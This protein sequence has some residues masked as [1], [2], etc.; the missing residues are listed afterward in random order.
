MAGDVGGKIHGAIDLQLTTA[1]NLTISSSQVT[2]GGVGTVTSVTYTG[3][4]V[5]QSA[6]PTTAVTTSGTLT[7]TLKTQTANTHLAGPTTGAAATPTFRAMVTA[8]LPAALAGTSLNLGGTTLTQYV[9]NSWSPVANSFT[10]SG[11]GGTAVW[12]ASYTRIGRIVLLT[13]T[14]TNSNGGTT[15]SAT[16]VSNITGLPVANVGTWGAPCYDQG[17]GS[18]IANGILN[19]VGSLFTPTWTAKTAVCI[20]FYYLCGTD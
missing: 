6:T 11:V 4:G 7:A 17:A 16:G 15:T 18:F 1:P 9:A 3:D 14:L 20:T 12:S 8:D 19:G 2:G 10:F 13:A 5:V